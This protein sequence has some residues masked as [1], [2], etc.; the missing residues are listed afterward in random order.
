MCL[1]VS[2]CKQLGTSPKDLVSNPGP[3]GYETTALALSNR[4]SYV[5][6]GGYAFPNKMD[7]S[8]NLNA[9]EL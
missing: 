9:L 4:P 2:T 8:V 3:S 7:L 1:L 6:I 5:E